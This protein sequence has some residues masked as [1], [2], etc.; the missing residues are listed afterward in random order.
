MAHRR[1]RPGPS[2]ELTSPTAD[3]ALPASWTATSIRGTPAA[4][5][6]V[7]L[8]PDTTPPVVPGT[9]NASG[10]TQTQTTLNWGA[11]TDNQG[12]AGYQVVRNGTALPGTVTGLTFTDTSLSPSNTYTYTV[13]AIDT[14]NLVGPDTNSVTVTTP[15]TPPTSFTDDFTGTNGAAWKPCVDDQQHQRHRHH[16]VQQRPTRGQ[17]H[18]R[19]LRPGPT[20][21]PRQHRE[22][23]PGVLLPV[24]QLGERR[25]LQRV[26]PR[27]GRLA[28]QLPA[29]ER[30]RTRT[31]AQQFHRAPAKK[32]VNGTTTTLASTTG[33]QQVGTAKQWIRLRATGSTIQYRIWTDGQAEPTTWRATVTDTSVTAAGQT[34]ISL[35]R[36][37]SATAAPQRADGRPAG[38]QPGRA[39]QPPDTTPP[40]APGHAERGQAPPRPRPP[41]TGAQPPTTK[42]WPATRWSATAPHCQAP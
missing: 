10:T 17:Q 26:H 34:H 16:P 27:L 28:Q 9:L 18:Q 33:A 25:V 23:R 19:R 13:R 4:T 20:Q 7:V 21:R 30:L 36:S 15:A 29:Q 5:N 2:L 14:S 22:H 41:S 39:R 12:V 24:G 32:V 37:S 38:D 42:A 40:S 8:I 6:T 1:R 31:L 11:A 35:V 3:N